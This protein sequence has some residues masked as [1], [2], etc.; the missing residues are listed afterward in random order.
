MCADPKRQ[1]NPAV[2][3]ELQ[4]TVAEL[5]AQSKQARVGDTIGPPSVVGLEMGEIGVPPS[6][7]VLVMEEM[8]LDD[9][10]GC[11]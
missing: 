1:L 9:E 10:A 7:A 2:E 5:V 11:E 6:D 3:A 8:G 4:L